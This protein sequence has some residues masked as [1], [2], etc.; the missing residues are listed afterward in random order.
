MD[1]LSGARICLVLRSESFS[2]DPLI[3]PGF[4]KG[5][6]SAKGPKLDET[7]V[8]DEAENCRKT[9]DLMH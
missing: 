5:L 4:R 8:P 7:V 9:C 2:T 1:D 3:E 6:L